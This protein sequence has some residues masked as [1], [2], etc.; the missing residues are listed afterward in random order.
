MTGRIIRFNGKSVT[1]A[2]SVRRL[3]T[4]TKSRLRVRE[5]IVGM[6]DAYL[7]GDTLEAIGERHGVTRERIRQLLKEHFGI[8][9]KDSGRIAASKA[10]KARKRSDF[11]SA[12]MPKYGC[13]KEQFRTVP[14]SVREHY[15]DRIEYARRKGLT[16]GFT[17]LDFF[18]GKI[19]NGSVAPPA[20]CPRCGAANYAKHFSWCAAAQ[21]L[22]QDFSR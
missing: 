1:V 2:A 8:T 4:R 10:R 21:S 17:L 9:G 19:E 20:K 14:L 3:P 11:L 22:S 13:T 6:R 18:A 15:R 16:V 12:F 7:E 5:V